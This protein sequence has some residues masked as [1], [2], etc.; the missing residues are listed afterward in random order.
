MV[1]QHRTVAMVAET[2][3]REWTYRVVNVF[4][5]DSE[6]YTQGLIYRDGFLFEST[7]LK[8]RSTLR[9]VRL[10]TGEVVQQVH[11]DP[12]YFAEGL[13]D[14][15]EQLVQLTWTSHAGFLYDLSTFTL[16]RTFQYA[17][18]GWGL[19]HDA[20]NLILSDGSETLRFLDPATFRE[21]RRV[22]VQ[23]NGQPVT[24]LNELE[25]V[26]GE[27]FANVWHSDRIA[28]IDP[29]SGSVSG[30]IEL[31]GLL[32]APYRM[33]SEAVL[34]GI[35]FDQTHDRLFVT[36]KLWPKLFE[37]RLEPASSQQR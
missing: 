9:K 3:P 29:R 26:R 12:A 24:Q 20:E 37:I 27:V 7:G 1:G 14:W 34:N 6:A 2:A 30:W 16:K 32:S 19:T 10:E 18:E 35:A 11:L 21:V 25:I 28:M 31:R 4:P 13:T 15:H 23:E 5:H 17:G 8:G 36:G 33:D 22:S